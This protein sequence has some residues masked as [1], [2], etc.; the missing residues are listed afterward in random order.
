MNQVSNC[1]DAPD[2]KVSV[3]AWPLVMAILSAIPKGSSIGNLV[4]FLLQFLPG[5]N[6][7]TGRTTKSTPPFQVNG[8]TY[9]TYQIF[10]QAMVDLECCTCIILGGQTTPNPCKP[11]TIPP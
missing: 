4:A 10:A 3:N 2:C 6:D 8:K 1:K 7:T 9:H 5:C 11:P